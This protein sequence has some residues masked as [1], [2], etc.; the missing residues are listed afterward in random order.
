ME[1]PKILI[2]ASTGNVGTYVSESLYRQNIP[3]IAST[4][5][6]NKAEKKLGFKLETRF[7]DFK[8]QKSFAQALQD[9]EIL[10]LCGPSATPGAEELLMPLVEEAEKQKVKH[11][12]FVASYPKV[13]EKIENSQ[14][15]YT[16]L[17]ANFFMQNF[18][19]YQTEDI[20][21]RDQILM[22]VGEGKAPFIHTR[23][24]GEVA[25]RI[26]SDPGNY[27]GETLFLTGKESLDHFKV[28][29]IFSEVLGKEVTFLNP[30]EK[31]YRIIMR[32]R[33]FSK[34]WIDAMIAVF[35]KIKSGKVNHITDTVQKVLGRAPIS[36]SEYAIEKKK[37]FSEKDPIPVL[38]LYY[39]KTGNTKAL[40]KAIAEG[41]NSI[42]GTKAI[43][44]STAQVTKD[45]FLSA[46][47]IIA[48]SPVYFGGMA[49][50]L[51]KIF[52]DFVSCRKRSEGKIGA[53]F[54]TAANVSGGKETTMLSIHQSLLIYGMVITGDPLSA[55]GHYG[56][57]CVGEPDESTKENGAKLGARVAELV[58]KV[59]G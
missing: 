59:F 50:E 51:K 54:A 40:A 47:G 26:I 1:H 57:S 24:I 28:A 49:A 37:H 45:E 10:F 58:Q 3:F 55:T 14:M 29:Q 8:N 39:S 34:P 16:F 2:T 53:A 23:D 52:D 17:K 43:L 11:V 56:T 35:G 44:R 36:L 21:D 48:G 19:I 7:L 30:D 41:V 4:R 32:E 25:A 5:N 46:K 12:V 38:V 20:R 15:K 27:E 31:T 22:P 6:S 42:S 9:I 18:E 13:M 33:G